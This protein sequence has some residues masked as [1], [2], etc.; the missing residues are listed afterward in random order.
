MSLKMTRTATYRRPMLSA[1]AVAGLMG[2]L[3]FTTLATGL[4][5][6][7]HADDHGS[8]A[9]A[10]MKTGITVSSPWVRA[11]PPGAKVGAGYVQLG[12]AGGQA[13]RLVA[14]SAPDI[15]GRVE[16][17]EMSMDDGIMKMRELAD[18]LEIGAGSNVKLKPG[19]FHLM[20][21]DLKRPIEE[22]E[23]VKMSLT[24]KNA[25]QMDVV[26]KAYGVGSMGPEGAKSGPKSGPKSGHEG[27]AGHGGGH[28]GE[29]HGHGE[30]KK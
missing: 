16:I 17:H 7:A 10:E 21:M 18:G 6:P 8:H 12:N 29:H 30:M 25:G 20:L 2:G 4:A 22:G 19:G 9:K 24:F 15:A 5:R 14:A 28:H 23:D 27:H 13:D 11:T 1:C 26:F 3:A